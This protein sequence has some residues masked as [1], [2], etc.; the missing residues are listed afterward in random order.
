MKIP[1]HLKNFIYCFL[2]AL[3]TTMAFPRLEISI[4]IWIALI[5]L[6]IVLDGKT[7]GQ[8]FRIGFLAG[9][10]TFLGTLYWLFHVTAWFSV[11]AAVGVIVLLLYLALYYALFGMAYCYSQ[12]MSPSRRLLFLPSV[13]VV[14]E[15]IRAHLFTGFDWI[16]LGHSQFRNLI[17]IQIADFSGV[18]GVSFV[19]VMTNIFLKEIFQHR[20][21][22]GSDWLWFRCIFLI[23]FLGHFFYGVIRL[24]ESLSSEK[25]RV[26]IVQGNIDQDMKWKPFAWPMIM[27]AHK[28]LTRQ[29]ALKEPELII[30]PET[31]FPG[32]KG[33]DDALFSEIEALARE[34][35][36]PILLGAIEHKN[37]DYFNT[38][39]LMNPDGTIA[40][41]YNKIHLVPFG[42]FLPGRNIIGSLAEW[43]P[44]SDFTQGKDFTVFKIN[45]K[46]FSVLICFEDT[47]AGMSPPF[48]RAGAKLLINMTN[49][50][51]F[52]DSKAPTLHLS[53]SLFRTVENRRSLIR[54][55]NTGLSNAIDPYGRILTQIKDQHGTSVNIQGQTVV[56]VPLSE[57]L[58]F[59][60]KFGNAFVFLCLGCILWILFSKSKN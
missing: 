56:D 42:E 49:D 5:P 59:Y 51:W 41:Q 24:R 19:I 54:S 21:S 39:M 50:A 29:V 15:F 44:I 20:K 30:W 25:L 12:L 27:N 46:P 35:K 32:I 38:V 4:L 31:S 43:V 1:I 40:Q 47:I 48:V 26:G 55:A 22:S 17:S 58:T 18:F 53:S 36:R 7:L 45:G 14:L 13:W 60:T 9:F 11:V 3:L 23:V 37:E 57:T 10:L 34:V 33:E 6:M 28:T 16:S 8:G 2:T 52:K